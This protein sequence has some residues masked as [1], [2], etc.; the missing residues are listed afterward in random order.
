M[1]FF[2]VCFESI[3]QKAKLH[4]LLGVELIV[5]EPYASDKRTHPKLIVRVCKSTSENLKQR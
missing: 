2:H 5:F 3:L 4:L 1:L